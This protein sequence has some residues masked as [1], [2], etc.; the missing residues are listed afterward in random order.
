MRQSTFSFCMLMLITSSFTFAQKKVL[1]NQSFEVNKGASVIF[2]LDNTAIGVEEST[3][4][5]VHFNYSVEFNNYSKK[6]IA[7][8]IEQI[9]VEVTQFDNHITL[10][11]SSTS[12]IADQAYE[13]DAQNGI[14]FD[15]ILL[16][17]KNNENKTY[18]KSK[19]SI[20]YEINNP[21]FNFLLSK[22]KMI[23]SDGKKKDIN[24]DKVRMYKSQFVIKVP[25]DVKL[26]FNGKDSQ[27]TFR[28]SLTNDI[29]MS[30]KHGFFKG[31]HLSNARNK[32]KIE[33][34]TFKTESISGG[35]YDFINVRQG[36]IGSIDKVIINS[37]F[38]KIEIGEIKQ[39][40][41]ITDF[42]SEYWLYNWS[43]NFQQFDL[44]SQYSK[45]Y[46][47][48]PETD[49]SLKAVGNNTI[50]YVGNMKIDMQPTKKDEKYVMMERKAKNTG[51]FAGVINL[52]IVH[53][54]IYSYSDSFKPS[55]Y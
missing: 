18:R 29:S 25:K 52:D 48:Y 13:F 40:V 20:L 43:K 3:D 17:E 28:S 46:Y 45:L 49:Y 30:I 33:D 37:E 32:F 51:V 4:G 38:S 55:K 1:Y 22:F 35:S 5:K 16:K 8:F 15:S 42:N 44:Y 10:K 6:E 53:G 39:D 24:F 12:K 31:K 26:T 2:N 23:D 36:L 27:I 54:I 14:V 50:N 41:M 47:F 7:K 19:D 21:N 9:N 34:A 11:A